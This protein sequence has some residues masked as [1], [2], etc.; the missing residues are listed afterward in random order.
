M[1]RGFCR[2]CV[3]RG[4]FTSTVAT[5]GASFFKSNITTTARGEASPAGAIGAK[6]VL[7]IL[8]DPA[9]RMARGNK[10]CTTTAVSCQ[11]ASADLERCVTKLNSTCDRSN[12]LWTWTLGSCSPTE[13]CKPRT[14]T[15]SDGSP[16]RL[17]EHRTWLLEMS[18]VGNRPQCS[19][20]AMW[21]LPDRNRRC[22]ERPQSRSLG[23]SL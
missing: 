5:S 10:P 11:I 2:T 13:E 9:S 20:S 12:S 23:C 17:Q 22:V 7:T 14:T 18:K 15:S 21:F 4:T 6:V 19:F 16:S 1:Q 3:T 8:I